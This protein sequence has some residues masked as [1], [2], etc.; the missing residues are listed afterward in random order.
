MISSLTVGYVNEFPTFLKT[1]VNP[2]DYIKLGIP[3]NATAF[4]VAGF[5]TQLSLISK[6]D[7]ECRLTFQVKSLQ[8]GPQ[9]LFLSTQSLCETDLSEKVALE[10][11]T[12]STA[13]ARRVQQLAKSL[14]LDSITQAVVDY[15]EPVYTSPSN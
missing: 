14:F 9:S 10:S 15:M 3:M 1:N 6:S 4:S 12:L 2:L 13:T 8:K 7:P 11:K 5:E